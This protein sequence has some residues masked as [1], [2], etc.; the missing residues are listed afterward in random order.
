M[1]FYFIASLIIFAGGIATKTRGGWLAIGHFNYFVAIQITKKVIY[2]K[3][4]SNSNC[5]F[6]SILIMDLTS[7]G[8]IIVNRIMPMFFELREIS[9]GKISSDLAQGALKYG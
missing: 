1:H 5:K 7:G 3:I 6:N 4:F 2:E 9:K 8:A